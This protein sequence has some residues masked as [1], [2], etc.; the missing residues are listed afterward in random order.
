MQSISIH[1]CDARG[2]RHQGLTGGW[3]RFDLATSGTLRFEGSAPSPERRRASRFWSRRGIGLRRAV[4]PADVAA[5]SAW[6]R[7]PRADGECWPGHDTVGRDG[8]RRTTARSKRSR[9]ASRLP[10]YAEMKRGWHTPPTTAWAH[11]QA[12]RCWS[13]RSST[14]KSAS[15]WHRCATTAGTEDD[16]ERA[17]HAL[18]DPRN[19]LEKPIEPRVL[20]L[21]YRVQ[22]ALSGESTAGGLRVTGAA[23]PSTAE[24]APSTSS[25]RRA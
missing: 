23:C 7:W 22:G 11:P 19:N 9:T 4:T 10:A 3:I 20:D 24:G 15:S 16:L 25:Y 18:R 5:C 13:W 12:G 21:A 2:S 14:P 8:G 1:W 17:S 6:S